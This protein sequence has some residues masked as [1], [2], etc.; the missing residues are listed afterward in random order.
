MKMTQIAPRNDADCMTTH[1]TLAHHLHKML[2]FIDLYPIY[3][4]LWKVRMEG[5]SNKKGDWDA[6]VIRLCI[7]F[8][9][10][11]VCRLVSHDYRPMG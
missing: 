4:R 11:V 6:D 10:N 3:R 1:I 9:V 2:R 5:H 8:I 7:S